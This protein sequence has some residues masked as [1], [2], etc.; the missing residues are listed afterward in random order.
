MSGKRI[1]GIILAGGLAYIVIKGMVNAPV[2]SESDTLRAKVEAGMQE[3]QDEESRIAA[4]KT[5]SAQDIAKAY[6]RN[7][8]A[9]DLTFKDQQF[10]VTGVVGEINTDY[11]GRAYV[12]LKG[13]VN[14]YMD[15]HFTISDNQKYLAA[16]LQQGAEIMLACTGRGDVAKTPMAGECSFVQ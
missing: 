2:Q 14:R 11:R 7:T 15:P 4:L 3:R 6:S 8:V 13:G 16:D 10:K 1:I 9:A 12:I 5:Y